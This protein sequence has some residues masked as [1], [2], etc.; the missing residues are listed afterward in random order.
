MRVDPPL[1]W[2]HKANSGKVQWQKGSFYSHYFTKTRGYGRMKKVIMLM[3]AALVALLIAV[4]CATAPGVP[5]G[6]VLTGDYQGSFDS[7]YSWGKIKIKVYDGPDGSKPVFGELEPASGRV[8]GIFRGHMKGSRL[9]AD[10]F[11]ASGT[12]TGELS[13]DGKTMSGTFTFANVLGP[14]GTWSAQKK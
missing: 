6:S 12:V 5:Q 11:Q 7:Q 1:D 3:A 4:G 8:M 10:F 2:N 9:E 14:P 13:A